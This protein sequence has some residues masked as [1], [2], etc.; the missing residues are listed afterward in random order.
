M[1]SV[2][3]ESCV[4]MCWYWVVGGGVGVMV[5]GWWGWAVVTAVMRQRDCGDHNAGGDIT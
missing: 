3:G 4:Y 5:G 2:G 1:V